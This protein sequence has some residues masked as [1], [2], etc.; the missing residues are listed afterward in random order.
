MP[1]ELVA[2]VQQLLQSQSAGPDA[3][4]QLLQQVCESEGVRVEV[5]T[6]A[7]VTAV[8]DLA[9]RMCIDRVLKLCVCLCMRHHRSAI[10][11]DIAQDL[12]LHHAVFE[13]NSAKINQLL[14]E[15]PMAMFDIPDQ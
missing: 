5:E 1:A 9:K 3:I 4:S 7:Q 14:R 12:R 2:A 6:E 8:T 10:L 13:R 11:K 15:Q